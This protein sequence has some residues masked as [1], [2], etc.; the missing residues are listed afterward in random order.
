MWQITVHLHLLESVI[1]VDKSEQ[2]HFTARIMNILKV[3]G[4]YVNIGWHSCF[5]YTYHPCVSVTIG[6][7]F[8]LSNLTMQN[9]YINGQS[10]A[11]LDACLVCFYVLIIDKDGHY[12]FTWK[13]QIDCIFTKK[14]ID[15]LVRLY[16]LKDHK[17]L[18]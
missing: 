16:M 1:N 8:F 6:W 4:I 11:S 18:N 2:A 3:Y 12:L 10:W 15:F 13:C 7:S 17:K 9:P 14:I 5:C